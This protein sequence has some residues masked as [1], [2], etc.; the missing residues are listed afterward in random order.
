MSL[1]HSTHDVPILQPEI[2]MTET[3]PLQWTAQLSV[4]PPY[5]ASSL[6]GDKITLPPSA[7]EQLLS[8]ATTITIPNGAPTHTASF[9]PYNPYSLH[10]ERSAR[11]QSEQT[12]QQLPHPLT[13]RLVNPQNGRIV[14][15]GVREFSADEGTLGLSAFLRT[16]LGLDDSKQGVADVQQAAEAKVTV[17]AAQLS[18]GTF[19]K[20][21]PLEAGYDPEDWKALLE[22]HLQKNYTTLTKGEI[23]TVPAPRK[24]G[25]T[26]TSF[27]FLVDSFT[28]DEEAICILSLIHISE[29]TRP[30]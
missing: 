10:A 22:Q 19:V 1:A 6:N 26:D 18:K 21:R 24:R 30:Y 5:S 14:Y 8:V 7:L 15:A 17:H 16:A 9:D 11:T 23:L 25:L 12:F 29:P 4:P 28:P 27:R 3:R 13:F 20:L 2:V